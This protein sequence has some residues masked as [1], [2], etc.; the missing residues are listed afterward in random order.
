MRYLCFFVFL[1]FLACKSDPSSHSNLGEMSLLQYGLPIKI[2]APENPEVTSE[3][4]GFVQ[5][6][7]VKGEGNY[8]LQILGGTATTT[9]V[10][11]IKAKQME[12][13]KAT[14][15]FS[16]I[17]EE[18]D[19]GFIFEKEYSPDRINYDFRYIK[20]QGDKEYIFQTG[21][22]GSFTLDEVKRMYGSIK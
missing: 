18:D 21:L 11:A 22:I 12:D 8:Y 3:D 2:M 7:T 5:D 19:S 15:Y 10:N 20:V 17:V 1:L 16:K 4:L 9:D 6:V 13:L 14:P